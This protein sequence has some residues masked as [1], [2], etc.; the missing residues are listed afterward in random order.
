M[1]RTVALDPIVKVNLV[2]CCQEKSVPHILMRNGDI[3]SYQER[4][5]EWVRSN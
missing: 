4:L 2:Y 1:K 5:N 3:Y